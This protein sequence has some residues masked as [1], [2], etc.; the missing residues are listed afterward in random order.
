MEWSGCYFP[1]ARKMVEICLFWLQS[2]CNKCAH[3]SL[4]WAARHP[5]A[6]ADV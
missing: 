4:G 2:Y 3:L 1:A 6:E 5:I